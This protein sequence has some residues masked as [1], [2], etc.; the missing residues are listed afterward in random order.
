MAAPGIV[1]Q[2]IRDKFYSKM[3]S[4]VQSDLR[5]DDSEIQQFT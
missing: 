5:I 4:L 3:E 1:D 2:M